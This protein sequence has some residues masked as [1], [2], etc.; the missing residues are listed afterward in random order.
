MAIRRCRSN[1]PIIE[2]KFV[3][4]ATFCCAEANLY[5]DRHV[6]MPHMNYA[7][8]TFLTVA[9]MGA[10]S[11]A[12]LWRLGMAEPAEAAQ[13]YEV[14]LSDAEWRKRLSPAAYNV[15]RH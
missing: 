3:A 9:G 14:T 8:R 2:A 4:V 1:S 13:R 10:I 11:S 12:V 5:P 15:L 7:R 6:W